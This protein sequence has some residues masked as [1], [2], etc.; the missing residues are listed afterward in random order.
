MQR[1]DGVRLGQCLRDL[2]P[3]SRRLAARA[4]VL[5]HAVLGYLPEHH[6]VVV[7]VEGAFEELVLLVQHVLGKQTCWWKIGIRVE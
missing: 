4:F 3:L 2:H 5:L 6:E 1:S 7:V